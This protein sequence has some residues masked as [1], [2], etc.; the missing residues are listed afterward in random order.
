MAEF[1]NL[2]T[3]KFQM[4]MKPSAIRI[5][6]KLFPGSELVDLRENGVKIHILDKEFGIDALLN[7]VGGQW[8]SIQEKYRANF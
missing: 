2:S 7:L 3:V 6:K 1:E 8:V 5:Y 4:K